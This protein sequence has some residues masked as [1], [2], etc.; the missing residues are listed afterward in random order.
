MPRAQRPTRPEITDFA[1][2]GKRLRS[3][4]RQAE[5]TAGKSTSVRPAETADGVLRYQCYRYYR[6]LKR[7]DKLDEL[8]AFVMSR[9][10]GRWH[11]YPGTPIDWVFR[12]LETG[13]KDFVQA[14]RRGRIV[15]ELKLADR[16]GI[17]SALLL[18]FLYEAGPH[19]LIREPEVAPK[20]RSWIVM[21]E[22]LS[23]LLRK[24]AQARKTA[25]TANVYSPGTAG[26]GGD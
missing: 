6:Q 7:R 17:H 9:D 20:A 19:V 24:E 14:P 15:R 16:Y 1:A 3:L 25:K 18:P 23:D 26:S 8:S 2:W 10:P 4:V 11:R 13:A 5:R 21:Y 12:L 22:R